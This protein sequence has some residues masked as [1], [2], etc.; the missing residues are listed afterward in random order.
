MLQ[1]LKIYYCPFSTQHSR[2]GAKSLNGALNHHC[3]CIS[4]TVFPQV[5]AS[6]CLTQPKIKAK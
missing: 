3:R 1:W 4:F 2:C 5:S 6:S